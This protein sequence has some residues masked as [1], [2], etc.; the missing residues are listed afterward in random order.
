MRFATPTKRK[1]SASIR[2]L[3]AVVRVGDAFARVRV[4]VEKSIT[5]EHVYLSGT[6]TALAFLQFGAFEEWRD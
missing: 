3:A 2:M 4:L 6:D 1:T 5:A